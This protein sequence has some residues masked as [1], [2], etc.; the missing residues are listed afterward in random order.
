MDL[1][2]T[3]SDSGK[4]VYLYPEKE[5]TQDQK[6]ILIWASMYDN[7]QEH[8][9]CPSDAVLEDD[10]ILDGWFLIQRDKRKKEKLEQEFESST[11]EKIK[12]SNV[13][14]FQNVQIKNVHF[15]RKQ[16]Q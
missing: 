15:A 10:D 9:E 5:I 14:K 13:N 8:M 6:G 11:N 3:L 16:D 4:S 1:N 7:I 2:N 12:N